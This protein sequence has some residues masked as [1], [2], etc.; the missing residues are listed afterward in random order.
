MDDRTPNTPE[1]QPQE[2]A[3]E[4]FV[5]PEG[6]RSGVVI[7]IRGINGSRTFTVPHEN[8]HEKV[9]KELAEHQNRVL[10]RLVVVNRKP[11]MPPNFSPSPPEAGRV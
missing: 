7:Q 1:V 6:G 3:E 5:M 4:S 8:D 2:K 9:F 11:I 10:G